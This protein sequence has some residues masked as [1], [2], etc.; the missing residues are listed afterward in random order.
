MYISALNKS[1]DGKK[2]YEKLSNTIETSGVQALAGNLRRIL[3]DHFQV[4]PQREYILPDGLNPIKPDIVVL[5]DNNEV[6][7]I[8]V[9]HA[10][11]P[12]GPLDIRYDI[13][14]VEK[15]NGWRSKMIGYV[16]AFQ[17]Y[18]KVLA[19]HYEGVESQ[20]TAHGMILLRW[21]F[22]I[23][24]EFQSPICALDWPSLKNRLENQPLK[25]ILELMDWA[26]NRPDLPCR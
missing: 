11:P 17:R 7:A 15:E 22:P 23:P 13:K 2:S 10:I 19:K 8:D 20:V 12:F 26:H 3:P 24:V 9:K 18:P 16:N 25:T 6:L 1:P 5:N 4:V 21:P 14:E